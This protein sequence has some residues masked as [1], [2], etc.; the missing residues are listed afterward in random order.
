M[1]AAW[2]SSP[3]IS[4]DSM[5]AAARMNGRE[6]RGEKKAVYFTVDALVAASIIFLSLV[7]VTSFHLSESDNDDS[8]IVANDIVRVFSIAKVGEKKAV[9]FTVDALVAA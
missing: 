8:A 5:G 7:L 4:G 2:S 3:C 9:Y 1:T 6:E